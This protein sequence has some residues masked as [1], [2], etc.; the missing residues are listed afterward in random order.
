[1]IFGY[2]LGT[3]RHNILPRGW[4]KTKAKC[5]DEWDLQLRIWLLALGSTGAE[6]GT[7]ADMLL[8]YIHFSS[9]TFALHSQ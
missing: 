4:S 8:L 1:L 9:D 2:G 3:Q 7:M 6:H 5:V